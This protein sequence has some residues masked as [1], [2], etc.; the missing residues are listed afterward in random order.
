MNCVDEQTERLF[1]SSRWISYGD[2]YVSPVVV[3]TSPCF[4]REFS[5]GEGLTKASLAVCGVGLYQL[6]VNGVRP[7][8]NVLMP[9]FTDYNKRVL[10]DV[11][12]VTEHLRK[13]ENCVAFRLG[14]GFFCQKC[15]DVW[16]FRTAS[17]RGIP[18]LIYTLRLT[19]RDGHTE[20][21]VSDE[22][23]RFAAGGVVSNC[24]RS[25]ETFDARREPAGWQ[26]CGFDDSEW[27]NAVCTA[28]VGI[29]HE[30]TAP[31]VKE[32]GSVKPIAAKTLENG[33]VLYDFGVNMSGFVRLYGKGTEGTEVVLRYGELTDEKGN[34]DVREISSLVSGSDFQTDRYIFGDHEA[35]GWSPSFTYHGFRYIE[36]EIRGDADIRP[37]AVFVHSDLRRVASFRCSD[38]YLNRLDR[39]VDQSDL[40][41]FVGIPTDCPQRE[42]NGWLSEG[43]ISMGRIIFNYDAAKAYEKWLTDICDA[44]RPNGQL[45]CIAPNPGWGYN[46]GC[47]VTYD[48]ALFAVAFGIY[49]DNGDISVLERVYPFAKAVVK[50]QE[51]FLRDLVIS[52]SLPDWLSPDKYNPCPREITCTAYFYD[53]CQKTARMASL[54]GDAE[55]A[56]YYGELARRVKENFNAVYVDS[57]SGR[58]GTFENGL[59]TAH[60]VP[61]YY[62][63]VS[64]ENREK[65]VSYLKSVLAETDGHISTGTYGTKC[66]LEVLSDNGCLMEAYE[67]VTKKGFPGWDFMLEKGATTLW[68]MWNAG[69]D[70]EW[71]GSLN[72]NVYGVPGDWMYRHVAGLRQSKGSIAYR[73]I[74]F[75]PGLTLPITSAFCER[76]T[77]RG[78]AAIAWHKTEDGAEVTLTV[79]HDSR[80]SLI[81]PCGYSVSGGRTEYGEG[82]YRVILQKVT[83]R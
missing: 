63:I 12:D 31:P 66:I 8:D 69:L 1:A 79:P 55:T 23:T 26:T 76:E 73:S 30:N 82:E 52:N 36:A 19:Y 53:T 14:S 2:G 29:L 58:I 68:E 38:E 39:V 78:R 62:G 46:W 22:E 71:C 7:T 24:L 34:L 13:G 5:V 21:V 17:W 15:D 80:A 42:K 51:N 16:D 72:H 54:V 25:G 56:L 43:W 35:D 28:P 83:V 40:S 57:A 11:I 45:S 50:Y 27:K 32:C 6:Y 60:C 10:Y 48:Y 4:R 49:E 67:M 9:L 77:V 37:E 44:M 64:D 59:Q 20:T 47:G 3:D 74:E 70:G 33:R 41:N 65:V 61:L 75:A 18:R 81:V